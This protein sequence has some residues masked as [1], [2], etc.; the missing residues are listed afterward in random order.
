MSPQKLLYLQSSFKT[1]VTAKF[2]N[3]NYDHHAQKWKKKKNQPFGDGIHL[4]L[5]INAAV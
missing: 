3:K 4:K 1:V 2:W 5:K